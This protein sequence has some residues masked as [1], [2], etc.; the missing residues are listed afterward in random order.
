MSPLRCT[1]GMAIWTVEQGEFGSRIRCAVCGAWRSVML[2]VDDW[3]PVDAEEE[4]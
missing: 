3:H 2:V 4:A 1:C